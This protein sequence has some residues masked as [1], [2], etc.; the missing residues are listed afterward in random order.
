MKI[1][2]T[3]FTM[4]EVPQTLDISAFGTWQILLCG[5]VIIIGTFLILVSALGFGVKIFAKVQ[6]EKN[7]KKSM[8]LRKS[9]KKEVK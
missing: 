1:L 8:L 6:Q 4:P 2:K 5:A 3:E 7:R 9:R